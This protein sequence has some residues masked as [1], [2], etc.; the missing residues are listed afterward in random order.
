M[1]EWISVE[2]R[3]PEEFSAV[4]AINEELDKYKPILLSYHANQ[5]IFTPRNENLPERMSLRITHWIPYPKPPKT[6]A[7]K[8]ELRSKDQE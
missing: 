7:Q 2:D 4:W 8:E 1:N 3:L 6:Q 5:F